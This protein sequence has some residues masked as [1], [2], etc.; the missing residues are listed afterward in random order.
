MGLID[1]SGAI[2]SLSLFGKIVEEFLDGTKVEEFIVMPHDEKQNL[3]LELQERTQ[4]R[5]YKVHLKMTQNIQLA[6]S[7]SVLYCAPADLSNEL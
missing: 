4:W 7:F 1:H 5:R 6:P 2:P 3:L